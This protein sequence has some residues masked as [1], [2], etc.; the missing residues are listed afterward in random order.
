MTRLTFM[1]RW[2]RLAWSLVAAAT[3]LAVGAPRAD[4]R[5]QLCD[6]SFEDCRTPLLTLIQNE[7]S[8]IDVGLWY[9]TDARYSNLLV[10]KW[11]QGVRIR[12]LMDPRE[13]AQDSTDLT[14]MNQLQSA[15]I[16]MRK[17]IASGIEHW[18]AM[19]FASQSTVYF[20][21]A[22]FSPDAFFPIQPYVNF[23]DEIVY[24]TDDASV[25]DSFMTKFDNAW[26]DTTN[27]ANYANVTGTLARS[28]PTSA[29][30][31]ALNFV[32]DQDYATRAVSQY[33]AETQK[34]DADMFRI[35]DLRHVNAIISAFQRGVPVRLIVDSVEYRTAIRLW[36][37]YDVDMLYMAG[38]PIRESVHQ[39]YDH[40]KLVLLYGL[41][42]SIFGSSNWSSPSGDSQHEHNYFTTN[43]SLFNWL[44]TYFE[45]RWNNS[46]PVGST[47]T[48]PFT[49]LPP[50]RPVYQTPANGATGVSTSALSLVWDGGPWGQ[51]YDIYFGTTSIPPLF[52]ANQKLGPDDP[53]KSPPQYQRIALPTLQP[54]TTYYWQVVSKTLANMTATGPIWSFTTAG[55]G[56]SQGLPAPWADTDIGAVGIAGSASYNAG[57]FSVSGS[58]ADIWG[59]ADAFHFVYQSL[60]GDG[61]LVARVASIAGGNSWTKAGVMIRETSSANA[62]YAQ[63]LVSAAK[64]TAFQYRQTAGAS[65]LSAA[66]TASAAPLWIK[67]V[68]AGDTISGYQ[69]ADGS[70]WQAIGSAAFTMASSVLIGLAVTSHDN[71]QLATAAFD[72]VAASGGV[73]T[74]PPGAPASPNPPNG[75][76]GVSTHPTL[77]WS[78]AGA[79]TY[80]VSFGTSNPPPLV[81]MGQSTASYVPAPLGSGTSYFWQVVAHNSAGSAA[82]PVWSFTTV[83]GVPAP[84]QDQDVGS[85]GLAGSASYSNGA[86]TLTGSGADIWNTADAFHFVYQPL[87]GDGQLTARVASVQEANVW[88]KAG[89]MIRD[90]VDPG[91][92]YALMLVSAARGT[93]FQYRTVA[94]TSALNV[95]GTTA[96]APTWVRIVRSGTTFSAYQSADGTTWTLIGTATISM[97]STVQIGLAVTSHNNA[98]LATAIVDHV[99][100]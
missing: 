54:G 29:I 76:T 100:Q 9:M 59:T 69:S 46:N 16:P 49:P 64:G 44:V 3:C 92:A 88:S 28:Y 75:A 73:G 81:S 53:T 38:I 42:E 79:T 83:Q 45:R 99:T 20:G 90:T 93:A 60:T 18:K 35:T 68:R 25:V 82:G 4:A 72:T 14:I 13:F 86:F 55:T 21:S 1:A 52:A 43:S 33:N 22:N 62:A 15:G 74:A 41:G 19:I 26:V 89:V 24:F 36:D 78:S 12:V 32:P 85:V 17:R 5:E 96:A 34:I 7:T 67:I 94:G 91:S 31:P 39:G 40:A 6:P 23:T 57:T 11:Q 61:Q 66:G 30:D 95:T 48:V 2:S 97:G 10:Q 77:T 51:V 27:Y 58:G 87:T 70:A 63:M 80:D 71:T 37:A 50:D 47:E 56:G 84:W 98:A 8:E 65:A